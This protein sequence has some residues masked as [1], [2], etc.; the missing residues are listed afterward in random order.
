MGGDVAGRGDGV[1]GGDS[2]GVEMILTEEE[3]MVVAVGR[4]GGIVG[5]WRRCW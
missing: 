4:G 5:G 2:G 1:S 3:V